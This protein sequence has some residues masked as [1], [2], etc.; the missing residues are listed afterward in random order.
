MSRPQ[1]SPTFVPVPLAEQADA[2]V[3]ECARA[4]VN[5]PRLTIAR[6]GKKAMHPDK[7]QQRIREYKGVMHSILVLERFEQEGR[8]PPDLLAA[9]RNNG[10]AQ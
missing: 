8:L 4:Q 5:L 3:D 7:V 6:K 1:P 2:I 10:Q 9:L